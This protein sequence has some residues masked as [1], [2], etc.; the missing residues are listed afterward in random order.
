[1]FSTAVLLLALPFLAAADVH[2]IQVGENGGL[3]FT[4]EAISANPGDQV[5][6][7]FVAKNHTA[8]QSSFANP[9]GPVAGGFDSGFNPVAADSTDFP[10]FTYNVTGT[11]PVWV[12]CKQAANTPASHCGQGMVFAINCGAD[13]SP[14]SFTNF[15]NAALAQGAA[16]SASA[17]SASATATDAPSSAQVPPASVTPP[18]S[19]DGPVTVTA[20]VT[21]A[22]STWTTVYGSFPNSPAPTPASLEGDVH[23]VTVGNNG[24][25]TF[26][27]PQVVAAP[28]DII[29]FQFV[30]K[31]HTVTQSSFT[32]PCRKLSSTSTTGQVGF[33]SGFMP[34]ANGS[35]PLVFNVTV[36][37]TSPI[38]VYCR[39]TAPVDHCGSGMVFAVNSDETAGSTTTF[40]DFQAAAIAQNGTNTSTTVVGSGTASAA[41]SSSSS[42]SSTSDAARVSVGMG[43]S[44]IGA[45]IACLL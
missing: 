12:Y 1:M 21:L 15:K 7:H 22:S 37:D 14:N 26:D 30:A 20:T 2:D 33:D 27:P 32:T 35:A 25:L 19:A 16:L 43:L 42:S 31:N 23:V 41:A 28:R 29:S 39:Q 4:P 3:T 18:P 34:V 8:T 11:T 17:A 40:S 6:F 24:T 36:N 5:V 44:L 13:G 38:W 45:A 9:C 10:T